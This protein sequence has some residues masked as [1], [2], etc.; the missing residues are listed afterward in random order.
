MIER[1]F[2]FLKPP[3][4]SSAGIFLSSHTATYKS[5]RYLPDYH[6]YPTLSLGRYYHQTRTCSYE[7]RL[8][9]SLK[10]ADLQILLKKKYTTEVYHELWTQVS[11]FIFARV[12]VL[13]DDVPSVP[14]P[15]TGTLVE[16]VAQVPQVLYSTSP[17]F[18]NQLFVP[19]TAV[20]SSIEFKQV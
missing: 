10:E 3:H 5:S 9:S 7:K 14:G 12:S 2:S 16:H 18:L 8:K 20:L 1:P 19:E 6:T 15:F 13:P 17:R 4:V 11:F